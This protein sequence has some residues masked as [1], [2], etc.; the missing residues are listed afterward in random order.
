MP[1]VTGGAAGCSRPCWWARRR[2]HET[3]LRC[4]RPC[5]VALAGACRAERGRGRRSALRV[6]LGRAPAGGGPAERRPRRGWPFFRTKTT[7][8]PRRRRGRAAGVRVLRDACA[9]RAASPPTEPFQVDG[10]R[11]RPARRRRRRAGAG[12]AA[13][14]GEHIVVAATAR[15]RVGG[16]PPTTARVGH[17]GGARPLRSVAGLSFHSRRGSRRGGG[18]GARC[19]ACRFARDAAVR[20][21]QIR[22][23]PADDR[24]AR[25]VAILR[26]RRRSCP[27][28]SRR[29]LRRRVRKS[30]GR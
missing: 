12:L 1:F 8:R 29:A 11:P 10:R 7:R 19:E 21:L 24:G 30:R 17:H 25:A 4:P 27:S 14:D 18:G 13:I 2:S 6:V 3:I 20:R 15:C 5:E 9:R 16:A 22:C 28:R 23:C 26:R